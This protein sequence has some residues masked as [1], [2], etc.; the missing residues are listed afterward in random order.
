MDIDLDMVR[1]DWR[2]RGFSCDLWTDPPG[3]VWDDYVH[4]TDELLML[5][6]GEIEVSIGGETDCPAIGEEI[7]IPAGVSHTVINVGAVTNRWLYGHRDT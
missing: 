2:A 1:H 6:E 7:F 4:A 3:Q 5:I